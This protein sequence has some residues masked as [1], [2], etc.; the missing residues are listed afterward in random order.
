VRGGRGG[1]RARQHGGAQLSALSST[2]ARRGS[3]V[4]PGRG[5]APESKSRQDRV[6][7]WFERTEGEALVG[8][9]LESICSGPGPQC[10]AEL[11]PPSVSAGEDP[12]AN[13]GEGSGQ[14]RAS[15][16][17]KWCGQGRVSVLSGAAQW[18][19]PYASLAVDGTSSTQ[20]APGGHDGR[21]DGDGH[22]HAWG[23]TWDMAGW[24][25]R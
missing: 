16:K 3:G 2:R 20:W 4:F 8:H 25:W 23:V 5:L 13:N 24:V 18:D 1:R 22:G 19:V 15:E 7:G 11:S 6:T 14:P 12:D 9:H 21:V 10:C 17:T